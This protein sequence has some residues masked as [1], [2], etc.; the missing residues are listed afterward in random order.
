MG[1]PPEKGLKELL[2][3]FSADIEEMETG[4]PE[5]LRD[6]DTE[7]DYQEELKHHNNHD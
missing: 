6:I 4:N 7:K 2:Q 5:I 3:R 1:F